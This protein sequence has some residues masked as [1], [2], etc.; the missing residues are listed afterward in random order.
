MQQ[1]MQQTPMQQKTKPMQP[2]GPNPYCQPNMPMKGIGG[3]FGTGPGPGPGP[4]MSPNPGGMT[5]PGGMS[6]GPGDFNQM[7]GPNSMG[8]WNPVN[9]FSLSVKVYS[10][11]NPKS[12][13]LLDSTG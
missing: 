9:H 11:L 3:H 12:L 13:F 8:G 4:G 2:G 7:G 5:G 10:K 6:G 1:Q